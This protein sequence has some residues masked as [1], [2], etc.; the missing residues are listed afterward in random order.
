[1]K[2]G[3]GETVSGMVIILRGENGQKIIKEIK[4]KIAS[5]QLPSGAKI[6]P[7]YDQSD[8]IN[9]TT[10]TV[11][12]NLIAAA[13]LVFV[14]LLIFL[15]DWRAALVVTFT[16]PLSLL[17]GFIGMDIFGISVNLMSLG[18]IDFGTI[19]DGSVVMVENC[20]HRLENGDRRSSL[21]A[22]IREA[23]HEVSRPVI[24][25]V[26]IIIAVYLPILTLQSLEGRMFRPMAVTVVSALTGSLLLALFI[27]PTVC[28]VALRHRAQILARGAGLAEEHNSNQAQ[29]GGRFAHFGRRIS[30]SWRALPPIAWLRQHQ[31]KQQRRCASSWFDRV[32]D[33]Y[34]SSLRRSE[35]HRKLILILSLILIA[36]A[37]G[38]IKLIGTEFMPTLDEGSMVV[39]V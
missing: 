34:A 39:S 28:T 27:V 15:G 33:R 17:F 32:R 38:S 11:R 25:G 31:V 14:V 12:R 7:F 18:A 35:R 36:L 37:L 2:D 26:L 22:N 16:I 5:L 19:V 1:M 4:A 9:A 13:V 3:K 10:A 30:S 23:A 29:S 20:I 6:V 8:V 21:I 24:F